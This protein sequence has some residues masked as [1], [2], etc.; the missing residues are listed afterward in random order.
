MNVT[1]YFR[2][3]SVCAALV[4]SAYAPSASA[5]ITIGPD[6][7]GVTSGN[8]GSSNC[9]PDCVYDAFGLTNPP[10]A[11]D[12][13]VLYYKSNVE[14]LGDEEGIFATSYM[15][16]YDNEPDDPADALI[17]YVGGA[18]IECPECYLVIKDGNQ[19]PS[20]YFYNLSAWD[21]LEDIQLTGF[22]PD[23]GAISHIS[24]W[25]RE[26]GGGGEEIPEPATLALLGLA[27]VSAAAVR[28]RRNP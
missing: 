23:Q 16:T 5:V 1:K 18:S 17:E 26:G 2:S 8:L 4:L 28:R 10:A 7:L 6:T 25:G 11:G 24:I 27:L 14:P 19:N 15:T 21:G 22:W 13:L 3:L 12:E 20:Y 9:E